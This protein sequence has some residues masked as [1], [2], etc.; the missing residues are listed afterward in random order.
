MSDFAK[1]LKGLAMLC[2][3]NECLLALRWPPRRGWYP[4]QESN[5]RPPA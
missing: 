4:R 2:G 1:N 5:L 3:K